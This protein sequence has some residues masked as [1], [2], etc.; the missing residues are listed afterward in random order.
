M[1]SDKAALALRLH[2]LAGS[3]PLVSA[4]PDLLPCGKQVSMR[5]RGET[6]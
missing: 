4:H 3:V 5:E 2:R 6:G 1:G